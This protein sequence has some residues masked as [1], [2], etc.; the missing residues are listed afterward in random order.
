MVA[1][2]DSNEAEVCILDMRMGWKYDP[3]IEG[4]GKFSF[5]FSNFHPQ[6]W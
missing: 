1:E 4:Q 6:P 3:P 5:C 2:G